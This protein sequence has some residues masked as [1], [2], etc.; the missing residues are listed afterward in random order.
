MKEPLVS[1]I[2]PVYNVKKY[3]N[4]CMESIINQTYKELEILLID[5]GSTDGSG[6]VCNMWK[7][8]DD[9]VKVYH[10]QNG[11][12]SDARNYGLKK[13]KGSFVIFVDPDDS[14]EGECVKLLRDM[15]K[16]YSVDMSIATLTV[17]APKG[18][19]NEA[20]SGLK[21]IWSTKETLRRLLLD[22]G[23]SVSMA[24]KMYNI[25]LF[26]KVDFPKGKLCEDNGTLYKLI[27]QCDKIAYCSDSVYNYY[28]NAGSIMTKEFN[29][30]KL[31]L[32]DL[33]DM[34]CKDIV[35]VYPELDGAC[36]RKM[37]DARFSVLRQ[38]Y[39]KKLNSKELSVAAEIRQYVLSKKSTIMKSPLYNKKEKIAAIC[40]GISGKFF[41]LAWKKYSKMRYGI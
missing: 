8:E 12:L 1:V 28:K 19:I 21:T 20:K 3:L 13:A 31:D 2:V 36:E 38:M 25:K 6:E 33:S 39:V 11:G 9:R 16:E 18:R 10:K 24:A 30:R 4:R 41:G 37:I 14:I 22:D 5:D 17:V 26:Q 40:L 15:I 23:F 34:M 27:M 29:L 35:S 32:I 7:R